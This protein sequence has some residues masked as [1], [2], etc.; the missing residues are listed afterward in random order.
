MAEGPRGVP[1]DRLEELV[2][3]A[4][5]VFRSGG[6]D[7]GREYPLVFDPNA[8]E[9]MRVI[10]EDEKVVSHVGLCVRDA[11]LLGIPLRVASIGAVCTAPDYRKRNFAGSLVEDAIARAREWGAHVMLISGDRALYRRMGG[12]RIGRY[13]HIEVP[14]APLP[15]GLALERASLSDIPDLAMLYSF[16]PIRFIRPY[17]DWRR[18]LEAEMLM[19]APADCWLVRD[20]EQVLAY[21]AAQRPP[22]HSSGESRPNV[23]EYAGS[24]EAVWSA[25]GA[26]AEQYGSSSARVHLMPEDRDFLGRARRSGVPLHTSSFTG[27]VRLLDV[28]AV[29]ERVV[30]LWRERYSSEA[31]NSLNL[32]ADLEGFSFTDE[33]G[34]RVRLDGPDAT[35]ALFGPE[36]REGE[37]GR[38]LPGIEPLPFFWYGYNY[39]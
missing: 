24:R 10:V 33:N 28:Q 3:L 32:E 26:L 12:T 15:S 2:A 21:I 16:E 37:S 8:L 36:Q 13:A 1:A 5:R 14:V 29:I 30:P 27:T 4:N 11:L 20:A 9:G 34:E 23:R 39:V 6:G 18:L 25:L 35:G 17:D 31:V 38:T 22:S 19:N 7:M